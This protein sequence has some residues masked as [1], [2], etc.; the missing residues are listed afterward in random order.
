MLLGIPITQTLSLE[1][2]QLVV[3]RPYVSSS[4]ILTLRYAKT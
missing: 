2:N 4:A 1:D 3:V